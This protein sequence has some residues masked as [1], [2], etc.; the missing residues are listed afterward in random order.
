[1]I[2]HRRIRLA[3]DYMSRSGLFLT[4][5]QILGLLMINN[6]RMIGIVSGCLR[7][8]S[9]LCHRD[10]FRP[11]APLPTY[12]SISLSISFLVLLIANQKPSLVR[13]LPV[14]LKPCYAESSVE[15]RDYHRRQII[16]VRFS[17]ILC[18][19]YAS[20]VTYSLALPFGSRRNPS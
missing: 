17:Q 5:D 18:I 9:S 14:A 13:N 15:L 20:I 6:I 12:S 11:R 3:V 7:S 19:M 2:L 16:K 1:M 8:Q 10:L 4:Y